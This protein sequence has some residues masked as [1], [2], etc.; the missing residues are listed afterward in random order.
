MVLGAVG[1]NRETVMPTRSAIGLVASAL[2]LSSLLPTAAAQAPAGKGDL[3]ESTSQSSMVVG[4]M[5]MPM[6][7][8]TQKVCAART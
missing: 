4:G 2:A 5:S 8:Q 7:P 1:T 6:P 3:W